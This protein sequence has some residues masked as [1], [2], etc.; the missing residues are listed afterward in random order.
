MRAFL[1]A[2]SFITTCAFATHSLSWFG[3]LWH[4]LNFHVSEPVCLSITNN[5]PTLD[6]LYDRSLVPGDTQ[7]YPLAASGFEARFT[8][9]N[10]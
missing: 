8:V 2:H 9:V 6:L 3:N 1:I 5:E 7:N 10:G 4:C